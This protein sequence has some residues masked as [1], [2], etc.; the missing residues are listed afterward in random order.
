M[1]TV[2]YVYPP[3]QH[4]R[5]AVA[6]LPRSELRIRLFLLLLLLLLPIRGKAVL[7][8]ALSAADSTAYL[9]G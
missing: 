9:C 6:R 5:Y 8:I 3:M 2:L 4:Y 7:R 1:R